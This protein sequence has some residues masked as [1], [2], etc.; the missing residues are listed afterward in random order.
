MKS[1]QKESALERR[2]RELQ[3]QSAALQTDI[4]TINKSLKKI[5]VASAEERIAIAERPAAHRGEQTSRL[6]PNY[7]ASVGTGT[8]TSVHVTNQESPDAGEADDAEPN[9]L[10]FDLPAAPQ[11]VPGSAEIFPPTVSDTA[12]PAPRYRRAAT[13]P[14]QPKLAS[15]LA[16]GSFGGNVPLSRERRAQRIRAIIAV[17]A[18]ATFGYIIYRS[19]FR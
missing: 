16:S 5:G 19:V 7:A 9:L 13:P 14:K 6:N 4:K 12:A 10:S 3:E 2:L 15:Y 11:S 17:L 8:T 1:T 18:V